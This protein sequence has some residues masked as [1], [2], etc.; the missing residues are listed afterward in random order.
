MLN[1]DW[2][3]VW[4]FVNII[5]LYLLLKLF[6]FKPVNRMLE[7][8]S[9]SIAAT[10]DEANK[11]NEE[12]DARK[13][14]YQQALQNAKDESK[15]ILKQARETATAQS[16]SILADARQQAA[17]LLEHANQTIALEKEK[18]V[19]STSAELAGLAMLAASKVIE[20]KADTETDRKLVEGFLAGAKNAQS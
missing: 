20:E 7:K 2:N 19:K 4:T 18:A 10:I 14:E 12:A 13:A 9:A 16:E 3:I 5:V 11:K 6:L 15:E 17:S 8:R 1:L